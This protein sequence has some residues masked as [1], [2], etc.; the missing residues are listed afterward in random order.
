METPLRAIDL[1]DQESLKWGHDWIVVETFRARRPRSYATS[2]KWGH[3][4]IVVETIPGM[5]ERIDMRTL[6][7]GHD[8][9]VVETDRRLLKVAL[10]P[11]A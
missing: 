3:D 4:W 2:L 7:W 5:D 1:Q 9:I 10:V 8:W 6:K 11:V